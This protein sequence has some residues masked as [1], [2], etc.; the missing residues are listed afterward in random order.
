MH[1]IGVTVNISHFYSMRIA[2]AIKE[3]FGWSHLTLPVF[4]WSIFSNAVD[5]WDPSEALQ[6]AWWDGGGHMCSIC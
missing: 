5:D 1:Y 3:Y 6:P 4:P 2:N